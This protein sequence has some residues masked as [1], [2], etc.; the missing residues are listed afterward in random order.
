[1]APLAGKRYS[2]GMPQFDPVTKLRRPTMFFSA[3][4]RNTA[5]DATDGRLDVETGTG[6][7]YIT[8]GGVEAAP[9]AH[10]G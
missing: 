2:E 10:H 6:Q 7:E 4:V 9:A 8:N 1:M 3:S 5:V